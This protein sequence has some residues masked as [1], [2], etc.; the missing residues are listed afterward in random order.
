LPLKFTTELPMKLV[1]LTVSV[2]APEP[3]VALAGTI[4][5][6]A[7]AGLLVAAALMVKVAEFDV[8]PPGGGFVTVTD[9]DP[10]LAMAAA[11][12]AAV[13]WFALTKVV[14]SA[15]PA[16][17]TTEPLTKLLPLT[18]RVKAAEP[19]VALGGWRVVIV[20]AGFVAVVMLVTGGAAA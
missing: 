11:G 6:M 3:A 4:D 2:N 17:S 7:G 5:V 14:V 19:A 13:S 1:P 18:V 20:G 16:K 12:I 8:P 15:A 10:L 9:T